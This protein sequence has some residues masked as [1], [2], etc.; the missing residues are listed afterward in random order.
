MARYLT[1]TTEVYRVDNEFE[2]AELIEAAKRDDK[3]T[4][5]KYSSVKKERTQKGEVI[6]SYY[7]VSLV[8][9]FN[10]EKEPEDEVEIEYKV[11]A[12]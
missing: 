11:G 12:F 8:K 7:K 3:Y 9:K 1:E 5:A 4:L 10:S 2:A 6:D